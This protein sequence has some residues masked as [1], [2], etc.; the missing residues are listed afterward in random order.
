MLLFSWTDENSMAQFFQ[1]CLINKNEESYY[2]TSNLHFDSHP[3]MYM[4]DIENTDHA[5]K[6]MKLFHFHFLSKENLHEK[7]NT[8]IS[9]WRVITEDVFIKLPSGQSAILQ[10]IANKLQ[11]TIL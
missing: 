3:A 4:D 1:N 5:W 8:L 6:E 11:A 10:S 9:G 7:L 2:Q